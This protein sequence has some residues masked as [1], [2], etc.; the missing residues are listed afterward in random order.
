ME[1]INATP[2]KVLVVPH[3]DKDGN[4]VATI[5]VKGTFALVA[6]MK[7]E[8]LPLD[9]QVDVTMA[10]EH[11]GEPGRSPRSR[12]GMPCPPPRAR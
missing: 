8:P 1:L 11:W 3:F 12:R 6:R 4:E 5:I 9:Q 2:F 7:V 10:D